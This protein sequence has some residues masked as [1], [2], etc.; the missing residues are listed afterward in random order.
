MVGR[1]GERREERPRHPEDHRVQVDDERREQHRRRAGEREALPDRSPPAPRR[2]AARRWHRPHPEDRQERNREPRDGGHVDGRDAERR[3]ED[4]R[5]RRPA[6]R[7]ELADDLVQRQGGRQVVSA[8]QL[9]DARVPH[10]RLDARERGDEGSQ[11]IDRDSGGEPADASSASA[12]A[13]AAAPSWAIRISLRLS[14]ASTKAPAASDP[15]SSGTSS[16]APTRPTASDEPVR[17][18]T[19]KG[20]AT[21]TI[22]WAAD[23]TSSAP[24]GAGSRAKPGAAR[25]PRSRREARPSAGYTEGAGFSG[26]TSVPITAFRAPQEIGPQ[27]R[28]A[29]ARSA[30]SCRRRALAVTRV[31]GR[32]GRAR[33]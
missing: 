28:P 31:L 20:T 27:P 18:Y 25:C 13:H 15:R 21:A 4:A 17:T 16:A 29:R 24:T 12:T 11:R 33:A 19:W 8:D 1:H 7:R 2:S 9:R 3:Q 10:R 14:C 6:E 32:D 30:P 5:E 23:A 26:V 22:S